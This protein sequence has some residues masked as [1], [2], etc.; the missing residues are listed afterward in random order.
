M[1]RSTASR[2]LATALAAALVTLPVPPGSVTPVSAEPAG[3]PGSLLVTSEPSAA[4]VYVD[5]RPA[6]ST[7]MQL[8]GLAAGDHRVTVR[9]AGYLENQRLVNVSQLSSLNLRLTPDRSTGT[10]RAQ[11][12]DGNTVVVREGGGGG[13]KKLLL[14]G[15]GVA[16]VGGGVYLL[17]PKN[18]APIGG[19]VSASPSGAGLMAATEFTFT[20]SGSSDPDGDPLTYSWSF[21]DG[22]TGSGSSVTHVFGS[23]GTFNVTV[24]VS[25]GKKSAT[26]T[27]ATITVKSM[28]GTWSFTEPDYGS[29]YDMEFS[30]TQ[31]GTSFTGTRRYVGSSY[32]YT[33]SGTVSRQRHITI[34]DLWGAASGEANNDITVIEG[35]DGV[36]DT[37]R[38]TRR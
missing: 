35:H 33:V 24:T 6:G 4:S 38:M 17:L 18:K 7:P 12:D 37:F 8:T 15:L 30:L 28:T 19:S 26:A 22:G 34:S 1:H 13:A 23:A 20:A 3:S 10:V 2:L 31:S 29:Y 25:D 5:G 14:I 9:K 16:A 21:G 27:P 36:G 32:T 11:T